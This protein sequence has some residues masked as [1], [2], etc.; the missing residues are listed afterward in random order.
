MVGACYAC[1]SS[2][3]VRF[4]ENLPLEA[5]APLLCAGITVYSPLKYFGLSEPGKHVG[6]VSLGGLGHTGVK[7]AK[8]FGSKKDEALKKLG[9]DSFVVS[10]DQEQM[11]PHGKLIL[12]GVPVKPLNLHVFPL[13]M[14]RKSVAGSGIG[15]MKETQEMI[16]FAAKHNITA[17]VEVISM[18]Y[19]NAA[20][21]R[22]AKNDVRYRF[23][24]DV[25]NTLAAS[26]A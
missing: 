18:D 7:F 5:G 25:A 11:K 1:K 12:V 4:P 19:V 16:D 26:E 24:I 10:C 15:G 9:A 8:A 2:L 22:L 17:E 23:V 21:E 14:G 20:M 3:L 13:I 6:I